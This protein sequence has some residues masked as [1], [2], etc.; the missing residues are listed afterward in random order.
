MD[1]ER[2]LYL[3]MSLSYGNIFREAFFFEL[4]DQD[5]YVKLKYFWK[6]VPVCA[7]CTRVLDACD[8]NVRSERGG[9]ASRC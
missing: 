2:L 9:M 8:S 4:I 7:I 5:K 1:K 6:T 3:F